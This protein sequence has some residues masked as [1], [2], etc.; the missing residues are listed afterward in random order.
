MAKPQR[1]QDLWVWI[2]SALVAVVIWVY[3]TQGMQSPA[4]V[5][6]H[7]PVQAEARNA[8]EGLTVSLSPGAIDV[9]VQA[10]PA[11]ERKARAEVRA[12][13]D[14][15]GLGP[16]RHQLPVVVP[17]LRVG[18]IVGV[19]PRTITAEISAVESLALP[20]EVSVTGQP[21]EGYTVMAPIVSPSEVLVRGPVE[22]LR[23]IGKVAL[24]VDVTGADRDVQVALPVELRGDDGGLLPVTILPSQVLVKVTVVS[25]DTPAREGIE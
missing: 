21:K 11:D 17:A 2:F 3:V 1:R 24:T 20:V 16:G 8:G 14:L 18:R 6:W 15:K 7:M 22:V 9:A 4:E 19:E 25:S 5:G 10:S 12:Y 13:V 23:A